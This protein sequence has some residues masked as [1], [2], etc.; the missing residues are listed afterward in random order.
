MPLIMEAVI[1]ISAETFHIRFFDI[2]VF[3]DLTQKQPHSILAPS[4]NALPTRSPITRYPL[5]TGSKEIG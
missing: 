2:P 4:E 1:R 3:S 5:F